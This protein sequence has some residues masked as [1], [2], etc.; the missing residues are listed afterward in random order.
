MG[1]ARGVRAPLGLVVASALASW[2]LSCVQS[3]ASSAGWVSL[4]LVAW[5]LVVVGGLGIAGTSWVRGAAAPSR[6]PGPERLPRVLL[7]VALAALAVRLPLL[8]W[9]AELSDDVFRYVWE[10]RVWR[11]G[12]S[13]FAHAPDADALAPLRDATWAQVN[14]RAVS[15]IYP[16]LAQ[17]WFWLLAPLGPLGFRVAAMLADVLTATVLAQRDDRAGWAWALLPLPAIESAANGHLEALGCLLV[18]LTLAGWRGA[19]LAAALVKL[20]PAV[21]LLR[22]PPRRA[23]LWAALGALAF[24]P[25]LGPGL[26][27]GLATYGEHWSFNGSA[28]P[29]L[30]WLTGDGALA[31]Q[32][33]FGVGAGVSLL[34]ATSRARPPELMLIVSGAFVLL[35]PTVHPWYTLWPLLPALWLRERAFVLLAALV[36]LAYVVLTTDTMHGGWREWPL[37]RWLIWTPVYALLVADAWRRFT[38]AGP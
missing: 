7:L 2:S 28:W 5:G 24:L 19:G 36:P 4:G 26:L 21:M 18:A 27:R 6:G 33:L 29:L 20:L 13:P 8:R 14:H 22:E 25:M 12:F 30:S 10:G 35:S 1:Y 9:P 23:L 16:P 15:S 3:P 11:A 17:A 34:A 31:R 32:L 38:R 37:T